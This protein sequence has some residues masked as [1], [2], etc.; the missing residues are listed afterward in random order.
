VNKPAPPPRKALGRGLSALLP[1]PA[2]PAA[3]AATSATVVA[4]ELTQIQPNPLQ[5]RRHF[6]P[7]GLEELAASIRAQGVLQPVLVRPAGSGYELIAGERRFRAAQLA[8]LER[9]P[10]LVRT[11]NDERTFAVALIENLQRA[12]LNPVEQAQAFQELGQ[13]FRLTQEQIAQQTGKDRTTIA[14]AL[15][16]LRLEPSVLALVAEGRLSPG[17]ARPL[18]PLDPE[19]QRTLAQQ[20]AEQGWSARRVEEHLQR[21]ARPLPPPAAP[22]PRDPNEVDAET[23]LARALGAKVA[24]KAQKRGPKARGVIEIAY[25]DLEEFQRLFERLTGAAGR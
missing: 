19:H 14:N 6:A 23:Q 17:Q 4:L 20:I 13:R 10:A 3:A 15:R 18:I 22:A 11:F 8:G 12:D 5:P 1:P 7:A 21:L 2:A 24:I 16:L 9:I 25:F